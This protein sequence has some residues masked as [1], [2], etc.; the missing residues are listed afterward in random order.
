MKVFIGPH[1]I[2]GYYSNLSK[3][4]KA[5][6]VPCDYITYNQHK[7][8]YGGETKKPKLLIILDKLTR[9]SN[10]RD[11]IFRFILS[12]LFRFFCEVIRLIIALKIIF[13]YDVFIFGFGKSLMRNNIDL[14]FLKFLKKR[15]ISNLSHGAEARPTFIDG[16]YQSFEGN[17]INISLLKKYNSRNNKV[18]SF[19]QKYAFAVIG[20]PFSTSHF[21]VKPF[22]NSL[23]IGI[24]YHNYKLTLKNNNYDSSQKS[25]NIINILHSP[26]HAAAK[27]TKIIINAIER[28]KEKG[29]NINLLSLQ[30]ASNDQVINAILKC[31][32][33]VDQ[34]YSDLPM[35]G[36]ATE[37]AFFG[38]PSIVAGYRLE[39]LRQLIPQEKWPPSKICH[40][41]NIQEAI[42]ELTLNAGI[43]L[44]LGESAKLFVKT[45]WH[46]T[47]VAQKYLQII[48][49]NIPE[50][51]LV[52]PSLINYI[53]GCGLSLE[54]SKANI[55]D[56]VS[57]FGDS[58][59]ELCT[60]PNLKKAFLD[61]S[62]S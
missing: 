32:F 46:P 29:L 21:A 54:Q 39:E 22:I 18:V 60:R 9:I 8:G 38:K 62:R 24:P 45:Q 3:G 53:E 35:A 17:R 36:L 30:N 23:M 41:D 20:A 19:H 1:E 7:Y 31:D 16:G 34:V 37:A 55:L 49:N 6:N 61:F 2:A 10:K 42:E 48:H 27:G 56:M 43:R 44:K 33:V 13:S 15:V 52:E 11:G 4:F 5:L 26:S 12:L 25:S 28:L 14:I 57:S 51:W 50:E 40:P 59:L 58:S 47:I